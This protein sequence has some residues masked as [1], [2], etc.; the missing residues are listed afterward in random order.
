[1]SD[2]DTKIDLAVVALGSLGKRI[3]DLKT[4]IE[5]LQ[6]DALKQQKAIRE[7]KSDFYAQ[8][9]NTEKEFLAA[10]EENKEDIC[11]KIEESIGEEIVNKIANEKI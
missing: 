10:L 4:Q 7:L 11:K 8:K 9:E 5:Q 6:E 1:M 3:D 2:K